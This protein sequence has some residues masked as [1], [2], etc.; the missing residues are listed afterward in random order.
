M[1]LKSQVYKTEFGFY[2]LKKTPNELEL[3]EYYK[4]KYFQSAEG[5]YEY[6]YSVEEV[7]YFN[8]KLKEKNFIIE[9]HLK[10][11]NSKKFLDL[12]CGEGWALNFF[13]K[14]NWEVLGLDYSDHG[15]NKFNSNCINN[16]IR[17][18]IY[19][20][21][22][23]LIQENN[24][25]DII[26]LSHVF[27]HVI[28]PISLLEKIKKIIKK[29][30]I[31][32]ITVPNDFSIVQLHV[33]N[34]RKVDR[35]F[36]IASPDHISYFTRKSLKNLLF[37]RKFIELESISDYPIDLNLLNINS[38]YI[39]NKSIGKSCYFEKIEFENLLHKTNSLD[40]IVDYYS[41]QADLG[42]GRSI[43]SFFKL[44]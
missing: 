26:N 25:F 28:D 19:D 21:L 38:N 17:G 43:T 7:E 42:I 18:D 9:K 44:K 36:W 13:K 16:L 41:K 31:L 5:A 34:T 3:S 11:N 33:Y 6:S 23:S 20:N 10:E 29:N 32:I 1:S 4:S 24:K 2:K 14:K 22:N 15:I 40:K 27:E 37:S 8:N 12:G 30:G 39:E 35:K